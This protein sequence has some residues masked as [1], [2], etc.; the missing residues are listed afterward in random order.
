MK[1]QMTDAEYIEANDSMFGPEEVRIEC[2][3]VKV[4][5]VRKEHK[6]MCPA[7][8]G[9]HSIKPG[10]RA[11]REKAIVDG[12][13]GASYVCLPCLASWWVHCDERS[14]AYCTQSGRTA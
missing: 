12:D 8:Q 14:L 6:C 5:A 13:W 9:R 2:R 7:C 1:H 4:V 10:E 3:T 11:V